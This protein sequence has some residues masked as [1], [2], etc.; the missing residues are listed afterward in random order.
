VRHLEQLAR[1]RDISL[2]NLTPFETMPVVIDYSTDRFYLQGLKAKE[3]ENIKKFRN[4]LVPLQIYLF[5]V[6]FASWIQAW[7]FRNYT[8]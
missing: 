5:F 4:Y 1:L 6:I 8:R 3:K 7:I 2:E